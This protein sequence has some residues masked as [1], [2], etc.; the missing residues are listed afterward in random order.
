MSEKKLASS[1]LKNS[2]GSSF[3]GAMRHGNS[4][5]VGYWR[6]GIP[7]SARNDRFR[8]LFQQAARKPRREM[9][10]ACPIGP[11]RHGLAGDGKVR[12]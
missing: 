10:C 3:C 5:F 4:L 12:Q 6:G 7:C 8:S 11:M 2:F 1:L 9:A